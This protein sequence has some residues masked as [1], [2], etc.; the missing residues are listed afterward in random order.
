MAAEVLSI[1]RRPRV[2]F[3][4]LATGPELTAALDEVDVAG[5]VG[6]DVAAGARAAFR[7]TNHADW[8]RLSYLHEMCRA[9]SGTLTRA[10]E[11]DAA[12]AAAAFGWSMAM[13]TAQL[14]LAAGVLERL[15]DLGEALH[16]GWL[17]QRK[18][19]AFVTVLADVD[20]TT[21]TKVVGDVLPEAPALPVRQLETRVIEAAM[22][23]DR[24]FAARR[25]AAARSRA[26]LRT[27]TTPAGTVGLSVHDA[28]P[29]TA[30]DAYL[31]VQTLARAIRARLRRR[32]HR[33][34]LGYI[35]CHTLLRLGGVTLL[36][37]DDDTVIATITDELA[38]DPDTPPDDPTDPN[39][40]DGPGPDDRGPSDDNPPEG[41]DP[42]GE[43]GSAKDSGPVEDDTPPELAALEEGDPEVA[44]AEADRVGQGPVQRVPLLAGVAVR[45]PLT[46]LLGLDDRPGRL[47]GLGPVPGHVAARIAYHRR[48]AR[49]RLLLHDPAGRLEYLLDLGPPPGATTGH[50]RRQILELTAETT[51]FEGLDPADYEQGR[52]GQ[53]ATLLRRAHAALDAVLAD[54]DSHPAVSLRDRDRRFPG[55]ALAA[56]VR[57][58]DQHCPF[59]CCTR[60]AHDNDIDHTRAWS[61]D[62]GP[63]VAAN[64]SP[65]C[66][67]HHTRKHRTWRMRQ[68]APGRFVVTDP[69]GTEH[70]TASR[71]VDPLPDA[72]P[73]TEEEPPRLPLEALLPALH[74][75]LQPWRPLPTRHGRITAQARATITHLAE[76]ARR[77]HGDPPSRYD[78]DPDF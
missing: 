25:Y 63:T 40:D 29:D 32:G 26:R 39:P 34:R 37:A 42:A 48:G 1:P 28:D 20:D 61:T 35:A 17:E 16:D 8:Q 3:D 15:P 14:T 11:P 65:P 38:D 33:V 23:A 36:G 55:P 59:P 5:L 46:T 21:A 54:P 67:A 70:H 7:A 51:M 53:R 9:R 76:R 57:A 22:A 10:A 6:E 73:A 18:A 43:S 24:E 52:G 27:S 72:C 71:V 68:P 56:W 75:P 66:R 4:D 64:L 44:G 50:R 62:H 41:S 78:A 74:E 45:L 58:R 30:Q 77:R 69:T 13:A 60:L 47:P 19:T 49:T 31:H 2:E 12:V